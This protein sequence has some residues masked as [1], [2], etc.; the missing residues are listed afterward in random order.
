MGTNFYRIP[1]ASE[2]EKRK[3]K[4]QTRIRQIDLSPNSLSRGFR[5]DKSEDYENITP[6]DEFTE[7]I[8]IHLGKRSMGWKFCWNFHKN[9]Y[10]ND[11]TSLEAFVRSGRVIDEYGQEISP[12]EFLE[13]AY[14]WCVDG[15]DTQTYYDEN[16]S[17]RSSFINHNNFWDIYIDG[18][19]IS[20]STDFS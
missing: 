5:I 19:R 7:D 10:F 2:L 15:W 4:L 14:T 18:L 8:E 9:K 6:W 20:S 16:P 11:K 12:D 13:M 1:T 3:N 17:H